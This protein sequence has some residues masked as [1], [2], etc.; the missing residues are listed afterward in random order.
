VEAKY[1]SCGNKKN[2]L[3]EQDIILREQNKKNSRMALSQP[4]YITGPGSH[5]ELLI[6]TKNSQFV[7]YQ[8]M[9]IPS[10]FC[11]NRQVDS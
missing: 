3:W 6:H 1:L 4:P 7:K 8:L 10:K 9:N 2:K 11:S 5:V